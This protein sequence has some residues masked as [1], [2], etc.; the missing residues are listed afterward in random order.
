[1]AMEEGHCGTDEGL[2]WVRQLRRQLPVPPSISWAELPSCGHS[3]VECNLQ[4]QNTSGGEEQGVLR[5][6]PTPNQVAGFGL[7][8]EFFK[9]KC[10][11]INTKIIQLQQEKKETYCNADSPSGF[12]FKQK[13]VLGFV[14]ALQISQFTLEWVRRA[15]LCSQLLGWP[16]LTHRAFPQRGEL[17]R[18]PAASPGRNTLGDTATTSLLKPPL[19]YSPIRR[20]PVHVSLALL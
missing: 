18:L 8:Q 6:T 2:P 5:H 16:G 12:S 15:N 3:A 9:L 4:R 10:K 14:L 17:T 1:M 20:I 19:N 11:V 13:P 7:S